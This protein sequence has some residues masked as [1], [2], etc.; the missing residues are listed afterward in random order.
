MVPWPPRFLIL[1][2][3]LGLGSLMLFRV[4]VMDLSR[5]WDEIEALKLR[6]SVQEKTSPCAHCRAHHGAVDGPDNHR[7]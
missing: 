4:R 5:V 2:L 6:V 1:V 3:L 7:R